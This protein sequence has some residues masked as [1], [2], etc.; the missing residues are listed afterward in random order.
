[1]VVENVLRADQTLPSYQCRTVVVLRSYRRSWTDK[2][3]ELWPRS[4]GFVKAWSRLD[5]VPYCFPR[6]SVKFRCHMGQKKLPIMTR[7]WIFQTVIGLPRSGKNQGNSS[8]S[9]SG[10]SQGILLQVRDFCN[11]L[12]KS[13][14]SQGISS[15][16]YQ[17]IIIPSAQRSSWGYI[18]FTPFVHGLFLSWGAT[19][20]RF[21]INSRTNIY[22]TIDCSTVLPL[23]LGVVTRQKPHI[24][25]SVVLGADESPWA[26]G[27]PSWYTPL[28]WTIL[29][30]QKNLHLFSS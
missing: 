26:C 30:K 17:G 12:S 25:G 22:V 13:G 14:K 29:S 6:S 19:G 9:E 24:N 5:E 18:G 15:G 21:V 16:P 4:D 27:T 11:L 20:W 3:R 8:L 23:V 28:S 2:D 7:I 10:K 1:M